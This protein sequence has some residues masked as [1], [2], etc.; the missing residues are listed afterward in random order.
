MSEEGCL[1]SQFPVDIPPFFRG[2]PLTRRVLGDFS[3]GKARLGLDGSQDGRDSRGFSSCLSSDPRLRA[4]IAKN[5]ALSTISRRFIH[6]SG[7]DCESVDFSPAVS[8]AN[9]AIVRA[10]PGLFASLRQGPLRAEKQ[11][12][13]QPWVQSRR[14]QSREFDW[15]KP[16]LS[17]RSPDSPNAIP[18]LS[19]TQT[20]AHLRL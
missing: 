17:W 20:R 2:A 13:A 15:R 5:S 9:P 3:R 14:V 8:E 18:L 11:A 4:Q 1:T 6:F 10:R 12:F 16:V 7:K 19:L